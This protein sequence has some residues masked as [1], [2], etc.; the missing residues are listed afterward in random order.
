MGGGQALADQA[1]IA[2]VR[3]RVRPVPIPPEPGG[4]SPPFRSR[5]SRARRSRCPGCVAWE[6]ALCARGRMHA[7]RAWCGDAR[8]CRSSRGRNG[9]LVARRLTRS[10]CQWFAARST[11]HR[12]DISRAFAMHCLETVFRGDPGRTRTLSLLTGRLKILVD[13]QPLQMD[14]EARLSLCTVL[15][16]CRLRL[17]QGQ[18]LRA[19]KRNAL[20]RIQGRPGLG[21][22][23]G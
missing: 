21:G 18:G 8:R 12:A 22:L 9:P 11:R 1:G 17:Q 19:L 15:G 10:V 23:C 3:R 4:P 7:E 13:Q 5:E 6:D 2:R 16:D 20:I 14:A